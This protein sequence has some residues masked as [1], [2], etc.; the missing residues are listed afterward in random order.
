[1]LSND[2]YLLSD[3][4]VLAQRLCLFAQWLWYTVTATYRVFSPHNSQDK[5]NRL[6][7]VYK[8]ANFI[9]WD[10][11]N[12]PISNVLK[13]SA[14]PVH[15]NYFQI[16]Q[17]F[18]YFFCFNIKVNNGDKLANEIQCETKQISMPNHW[19]HCQKLTDMYRKWSGNAPNSHNL[20]KKF[21][22]FILLWKKFLEHLKFVAKENKNANKK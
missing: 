8:S 7:F 14:Q 5:I 6:R 11:A 19:N 12:R 9:N 1:M 18:I 13:S 2:R 4:P 16:L 10:V 20:P 21:S 15:A 17:W 3:V 22:Y